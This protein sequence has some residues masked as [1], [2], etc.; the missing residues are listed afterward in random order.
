MKK[1]IILF[2]AVVFVVSFGLM[3][4]SC[5]TSGA[6]ETTA[7]ETTAG[8]TVKETAAEKVAIDELTIGMEADIDTL[9]PI[10]GTNVAGQ[11]MKQLCYNGLVS[12]GKNFEVVPGIAEK[13][14]ISEDQTE[15]TFYLKKGVKFHNGRELTS[16]DVKW[17]YDAYRNPKIGYSF[18]SDFTPI[19]NIEII[20]DYTVK[21]TL[22]KPYSSFLAGIAGGYGHPILAK[23]SF[24]E[25]EDGIL[26]FNQLIGTG[27]YKFVEWLPDESF[28]ITAF[29][30]Y[31]AG[32]PNVKNI[33]F[34]VVVDE[35]VRV[36]ALKAGDLDIVRLPNPEEIVKYKENPAKDYV[37][38]VA[39]GTQSIISVFVFNHDKGPT[40]DIKVRQAIQYTI[41]VEAVNEAINKGLGTT[42]N[43]F[44]PNGSIWA[45]GIPN[46]KPDL[47]KAKKF[48][49]DAG[50]A[51]GLTLTIL[52]CPEYKWDKRAEIYAAELAQI[53]IDLKINSVEFAKQ[54]VLQS[55]MN[56][57]VLTGGHGISADEGVILNTVL[58]TGGDFNWWWGNY[59][60]PEIDKLLDEA[61]AT[62][63]IAKRQEIYK[64][65]H[66]IFMA[67]AGG[68]FVD[69]MPLTYGYRSE[70]KGIEFNTRG[71]FIFDNNKGIGWITQSN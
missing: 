25:G 47:E 40:K 27:P 67:E 46:I 69:Q 33:T 6:G 50:Y 14:D 1:F 54:V 2:V 18:N 11:L 56:W 63:D 30:D 42:P 4:V 43:G 51:N 60:S 28:K 36:S 45:T 39:E 59:H 58:R 66:K 21:I 26:K 37:L 55:E 65:I 23:E 49:A 41:D 44:Y 9:D 17:T 19:K 64:E 68:I 22:N 24:T 12:L 52:T 31:W 32:A 38:D 15:Y 8:E 35:N 57:E 16:E 71:D 7:G 20:D 48:L 3:G 34:K 70:F 10:T 53:G 13:W 62:T 61:G 5:K 29:E